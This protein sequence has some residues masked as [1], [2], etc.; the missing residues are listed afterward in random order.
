[1]A[2]NAYIGSGWAFDKACGQFALAQADQNEKDYQ[3]RM[4]TQFGAADGRIE[5]TAG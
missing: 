4:T 2:I 1:M 3:V 5:A